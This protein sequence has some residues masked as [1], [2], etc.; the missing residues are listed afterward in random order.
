MS[1]CCLSGHVTFAKIF[2]S[3]PDAVRT[4]SSS[5][6]PPQARDKLLE[7]GNFGTAA[8]LPK[9]VDICEKFGKDLSGAANVLFRKGIYDLAAIQKLKDDQWTRESF[10]NT[11]V[12]GT[13]LNSRRSFLELNVSRIYNLAA[14]FTRSSENSDRKL[15]IL[16]SSVPRW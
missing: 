8:S 14:A 4:M 1:Q 2:F 5:L 11:A 15:E 7:T 6:L 13:K 3:V 12:M 10:L 9:I 16:Q